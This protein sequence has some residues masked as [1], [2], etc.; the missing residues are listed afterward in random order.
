MFGAGGASDK[1]GKVLCLF[2]RHRVDGFATGLGH[3]F[4]CIVSKSGGKK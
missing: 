3:A 1:D 4:G 2:C